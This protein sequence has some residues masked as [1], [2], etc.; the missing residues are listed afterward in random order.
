MPRIQWI[1][2]MRRIR[3]IR[4]VLGPSLAFALVSGVTLVSVIGFST[5][6]EAA[7]VLITPTDDDRGL[8]S[9]LDGNFLCCQLD[10]GLATVTLNPFFE[11]RVGLE[12][13]LAALP[14][15]VTVLS[16]T[17]TLHLPTRTTKPNSSDVHGYAGDGTIT[18]DDLTVSNLLTN[19]VVS[20]AGPVDIAIAPVFIQALLAADEDFAGFMLRNVTDSGGVFTIWTTDSGFEDLYPTLAIEYEMVPEPGS[21]LLV[22]TALLLVARRI[23]RTV[24]DR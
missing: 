9:F 21:L 8:D 1:Q 23:R 6:A 7:L 13:A 22:G 17:L 3:R 4:R 12:F 10:D 15:G 11:E 24:E 19:F 18:D 20:A 14:A 16:A 5:N 2:R